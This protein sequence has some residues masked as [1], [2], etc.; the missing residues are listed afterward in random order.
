MSTVY[1]NTM[2]KEDALQKELESYDVVAHG[3]NGTIGYAAV[4]HERGYVYCVIM[5]FELHKRDMYVKTMTESYGPYYYD[6]PDQVKGALS[7]IEEIEKL[8]GKPNDY[9][10]TWREKVFEQSVERNPILEDGVI[11]LFDELLAFEGFNERVFRVRKEG[12]KV[13]FEARGGKMCRIRD[14]K[15]LRYKLVTCMKDVENLEEQ[16]TNI[17]RRWEDIFPKA[18]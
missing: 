1:R 6:V 5:R 3:F 7:P 16:S 18:K 10:R 2:S 11:V 17:I 13:Y 12:R 15:N 8:G 14:Y 4:R 9:M